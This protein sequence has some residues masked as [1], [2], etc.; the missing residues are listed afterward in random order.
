MVR[1]SDNIGFYIGPDILT[2]V[3]VK[4]VS[5]LVWSYDFLP[6]FSILENYS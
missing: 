4:E 6:L 5:F 2:I 1:R 3:R